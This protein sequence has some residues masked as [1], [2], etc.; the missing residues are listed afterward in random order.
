MPE[1]KP[2][3]PK[4]KRTSQYVRAAYKTLPG[5]FEEYGVN[6]AEFELAVQRDLVAVRKARKSRALRAWSPVG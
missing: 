3:L 5:P 1:H 2:R 4:P 6:P